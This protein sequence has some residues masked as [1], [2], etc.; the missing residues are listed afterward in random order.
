MRDLYKHYPVRFLVAALS[1]ALAACSASNIKNENSVFYAVPVGST[2]QLNQ[3][4]EIQG[5]QVAVYAQKGALKQYNEVDFYVPNCK[6]EI[7]TMN[8]QPR[9]VE[10]DIFEII[11]VVDDI[12]SSALQKNTKLAVLEGGVTL[13]ILDRSSVFNYATLMYLKSEKQKDVYRMTCQH[14]EDIMDDRHLSI[15][16]MRD[17]MGEIFTLEVKK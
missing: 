5:E 8:E 16:Q 7:Y 10:Q 12:E 4:L 1:A 3:Q 15:Q 14:W 13:G 17:A 6:F 9:T 2:L 11:K